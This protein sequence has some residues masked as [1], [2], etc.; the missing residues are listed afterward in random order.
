VILSLAVLLT[1][2]I[3]ATIWAY[4]RFAQADLQRLE[5]YEHYSGQFFMA[6]KP[7]L[8]DDE[9]PEIV[10][11]LVL[12]FSRD[13]VDSKAAGRFLSQLYESSSDAD[14]PP[15]M[16]AFFTKRPELS[17]AFASA[18]VSAFLA[19]TFASRSNGAKVRHFW[20]AD[21][22]NPKPSTIGR[23]VRGAGDSP[24]LGGGAVAACH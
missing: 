20:R 13:I 14:I 19:M 3:A 23:L 6:T 7:L 22:D 16:A 10:L 24:A 2:A 5:G 9:T 17:K 12:A 18:A 1:L 21:T 8:E 11:R 15:E 4:V